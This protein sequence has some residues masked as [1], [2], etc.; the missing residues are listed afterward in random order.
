MGT[1][2]GPS[3]A[4]PFRA[5]SILTQNGIG[6]GSG[7]RYRA[8]VLGKPHAMLQTVERCGSG[9]DGRFERTLIGSLPCIVDSA[10]S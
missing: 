4:V 6:R 5:G 9:G 1:L 10:G 3:N 8:Q 7:C 2:P